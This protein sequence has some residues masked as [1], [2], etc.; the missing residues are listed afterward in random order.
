M[1]EQALLESARHSTGKQRTISTAASLL[2]QTGFLAAFIVVPLIARQAMPG[3]LVQRPP[4]WIP[5]LETPAPEI[6]NS[7]AS[8]GPGVF[9]AARTISPPSRIGKLDRRVSVE[10]VAPVQIGTNHTTGATGLREILGNGSGPVIP[11]NPGS[12]HTIASVLERGVVVSR[13]Q[14]VYP[15]LAIVN[16]IQGSVHINAIISSTGALESVRA[17]SGDL[18]LARAALDAVRQWRF[19]PYVLNGKPIEVQTEVIVNFTLN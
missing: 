18:T 2:L 11:E 4:I 15:H 5:Q 7:G 17:V 19:R 14:P 9:I 8:A 1:F 6:Q 12:K 10:D 3:L 16:R 13:V